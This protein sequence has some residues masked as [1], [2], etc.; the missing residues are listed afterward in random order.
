MQARGRR[1]QA[2]GVRHRRHFD[3]ALGAVQEAVE[4]LRVEVAR[5]HHFSGEAVVGPDGIRRGRM[6]FRQV[7]GA[8]A[9]RH[10]FKAGGTRPVHHFADQGRL[11]AVGQRIHDARLARAAR[12]QRAGQRV[13]FDVDHDDVFAVFAAGQHVAD[14]GCGLAGGVDDDVDVGAG[15]DGVGVV[16]EKD[17]AVL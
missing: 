7:L 8:F 5:G 11:V 15:D 2:R 17:L 1:Q 3:G 12:Q 13:R 4:H 9:R 6:E 14:A 10:H 16:A